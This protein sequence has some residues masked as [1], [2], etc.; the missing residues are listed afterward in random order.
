MSLRSQTILKEI[1][2]LSPAEQQEVCGH[3]MEWY[4]SSRQPEEAV[5]ATRFGRG[6]FAEHGLNEA[7]MRYRQEERSRG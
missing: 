6:M 5:G 3:V 4:H 7:L 1:T 2:A